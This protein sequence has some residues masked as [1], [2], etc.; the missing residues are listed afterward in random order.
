MPALPEV[1]N[2]RRNLIR[3]GVTGSTISSANITWANT[4]KKPSASKLADSIKGRTI[5]SIERRGKFLI[6]PLSG[7]G[8]ANFI[9]HLGMTG[10]LIVQP[11]SQ[12]SD[13]MMRHFFSLDDGRDL[14]FLDSR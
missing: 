14:R 1:E 4:V 9:V 13:P 5:Q 2:T 8:P 12:M 10:R 7:N 6:L 11:K 3:A